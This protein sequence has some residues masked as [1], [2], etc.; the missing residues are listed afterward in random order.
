MNFL[1]QHQVTLLFT[2]AFL[3]VIVLLTIIFISFN[4][5]NNETSNQKINTPSPIPQATKENGFTITPDVAMPLQPGTKQTFTIITPNTMQN[6][7]ISI[8]RKDITKDLPLETTAFTEITKGN[9]HIISLLNPVLP[10]SSYT[11]SL[12]NKAKIVFSANYLS[13]TPK[14]TPIKNNNNALVPFLP[15]ET[16]SYTLRF[17]KEQNVYIFN[18]KY[19]TASSET[20]DQQYENA[21][22]AAIEFI[23]SKGIDPTT[24]VVD[25]RYS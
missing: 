20:L 1:K 3:A 22:T 8:M 24:I 18:F 2:G 21:K 10:Y 23:K 14:P 15:H 25:W 12:Q 6:A 16:N 5:S 13:D 19:D 4:E 7:E 9:K 17:N 11:V